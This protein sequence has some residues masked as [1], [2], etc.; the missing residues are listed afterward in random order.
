MIVFDS[1]LDL[2]EPSDNP[3]N[4]EWLR[5]V[6][7]FGFPAENLA[8]VGA[9]NFSE[10]EFIFAK[11]NFVKIVK[12]TQLLENLEE[13]CD[14]IMEFSSGKELYVSIDISIIDL[15][16]VPSVIQPEPGGLTSREFIYLIQRIKKI[17]HLRG[18]DIVEIN[19]EADRKKGN[20]TIKL[21]AKILS[22][23]I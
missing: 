9:R 22:E 6:I 10:K 12:M 3:N 1:H 23:I 20:L 18:V 19:S 14:S 16:F 5:A 17:K 13:T 21:G 2:S 7:D 4:K 11:S 8:V 15:A